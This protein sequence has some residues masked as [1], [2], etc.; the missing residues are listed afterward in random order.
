MINKKHDGFL[1]IPGDPLD[2]RVYIK[3]LK[4]DI[5]LRNSM[6]DSGRAN[7]ARFTH[8]NIVKDMLNWYRRGVSNNNKRS[9]LKA[10]CI[11]IVLIGTIPFTIVA[12][13]CYDMVVSTLYMNLYIYIYIFLSIFIFFVYIFYILCSSHYCY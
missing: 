7:V 4:D 13:F 1:F 9:Y 6:G 10:I 8:T 2:A 12:L 3:R 11:Y 5:E